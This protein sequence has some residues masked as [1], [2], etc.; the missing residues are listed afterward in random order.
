MNSY[1]ASASCSMRL[2][3]LITATCSTEPLISARRCPSIDT[4]PSPDDNHSLVLART[5]VLKTSKPVS[6]FRVAEPFT[7]NVWGT[8][9]GVVV[10]T[11]VLLSLLDLIWPADSARIG[12]VCDGKNDV[13]EQLYSFVTGAYH[14][15]AA[16]LGGED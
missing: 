4:C 12:K 15:A 13:K 8:L 10:G 9:L 11:S 16:L 2:V 6:L 7:G 3:V 5:Q 14:I 1:S